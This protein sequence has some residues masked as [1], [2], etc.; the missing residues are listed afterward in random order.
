MTEL[1]F[2]LSPDRNEPLGIHWL[3]RWSLAE[4]SKMTKLARIRWRP[5]FQR[6][7]SGERFMKEKVFPFP[8]QLRPW[9]SA[10]SSQV[11]SLSNS[12]GYLCYGQIVVSNDGTTIVL[13]TPTIQWLVK[14]LTSTLSPEAEY[15][16]SQRRLGVD[17]SSIRVLF[18]SWILIASA[19]NKRQG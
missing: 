17:A 9:E 2:W 14:T 8:Y 11:I 4:L 6:R 15:N 18:S 13:L 3:V 12:E 19:T 10:R 1:S 5:L 16:H 7:Y